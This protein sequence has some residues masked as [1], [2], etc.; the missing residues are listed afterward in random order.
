LLHPRAFK[1]H[2][3]FLSRMTKNNNVFQPFKGNSFLILSKLKRIKPWNIL[4]GDHKWY[5]F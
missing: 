5:Y 4:L 1:S 3:L 2:D